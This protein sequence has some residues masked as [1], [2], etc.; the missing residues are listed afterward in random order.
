MT[1]AEG[2]VTS[3]VILS[4]SSSSNISSTLTASPFF[5]TPLEYSCFCN[6]FSKWWYYYIHT[7]FFLLFNLKLL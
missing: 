6:R 5:F 4:V 3:N 1:P 2:A 7:H